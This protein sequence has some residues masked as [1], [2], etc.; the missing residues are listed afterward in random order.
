V[1]YADT[2]TSPASPATSFVASESNFDQDYDS[3][4]DVE[5]SNEH[6]N[7]YAVVSEEQVIVDYDLIREID[8]IYGCPSIVVKA[9]IHEKP[10]TTRGCR[11]Y[12]DASG[13]Q[14]FYVASG[15]ASSILDPDGPQLDSRQLQLGSGGLSSTA[16]DDS[17]PITRTTDSYYA[18]TVE[19]DALVCLGG[20][21]DIL[22]DTTCVAPRMA[23][24]AGAPLLAICD[25]HHWAAHVGGSQD[26]LLQMTL[27]AD[28]HHMLIRPVLERAQ[29]LYSAENGEITDMGQRRC[30]VL[31][32]GDRVCIRSP[33]IERGVAPPEPCQDT[34]LFASG[35]HTSA[36][37]GHRAMGW[38]TGGVYKPAL[39]RRC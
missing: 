26:D 10:R 5:W 19:S 27:R 37:G 16:L 15:C 20:I 28:G 29:T 18:T 33:T 35:G 34:L 32:D 9:Y 7:D 31:H 13:R 1:A 25:L 17:T 36:S 8:M 23:S 39:H 21:D 11:S 30:Q 24:L 3:Q 38:F 22:I 6:H 2:S 14:T 4:S 12:Y